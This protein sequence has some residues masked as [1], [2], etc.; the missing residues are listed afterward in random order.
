MHTKNVRV[1]R[2]AARR[3]AGLGGCRDRRGAFISPR[4][5][6]LVLCRSVVV[7]LGAT[8]YRCCA[9]ASS[10]RLGALPP[11]TRD[12]ARRTARWTCTRHARSAAHDRAA[13]TTAT[14]GIARI[15]VRI[16]RYARIP[17]RESRELRAFHVREYLRSA[18]EIHEEYTKFTR[19]AFYLLGSVLRFG[20]FV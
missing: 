18:L 14:R 5:S 15:E 9:L 3:G 2:V 7:L 19:L 12:A 20:R 1:W 11:S 17:G 10:C 16:T 13:S 4:R 6:P 8:A